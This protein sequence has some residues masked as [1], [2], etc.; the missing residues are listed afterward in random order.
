MEA[1]AIP[2]HSESFLNNLMEAREED[3]EGLLLANA[4][5]VDDDNYISGNKRQVDLER[6]AILPLPLLD[7]AIVYR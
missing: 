5:E 3:L 7:I 1:F 6:R 4:E 2:G